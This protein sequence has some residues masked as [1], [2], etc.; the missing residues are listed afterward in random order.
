M[1]PG[2]LE[3]TVPQV[4][5][6]GAEAEVDFANM[7]VRLDGEPLKCHQFTLRLRIR[8]RR[9][10]GSIACQR[11]EAFMAGHA[12]AFAVLGGIPF[13]H[14][15]YDTCKPAVEQVL[16][17]PQ[18]G[19]ITAVDHVPVALRLRRVLLHTRHRG[20]AREGRRRARGRTV[21]PHPPG[22]GAEVAI[23]A[24]LNERLAAIDAGDARH[25]HGN[26]ASIG[27]RFAAERDL[28]TPLPD[29]EF[30]CGITLTPARAPRLAWRSR[31]WGPPLRA[32]T[33]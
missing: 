29:E 31:A 17:W 30:D 24:E 12:E 27:E 20:R 25:M 33:Q 32:V 22:P 6:P 16:F 18:P 7:W 2:E 11:Q 4:H 23:L 8:A 26:T 13:R 15:R 28:L 10:T 3:G 14:I 21:H 1:G 9:C 5:E 19:G